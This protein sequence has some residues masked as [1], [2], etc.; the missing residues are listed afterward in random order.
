MT[1]RRGGTVQIP[2]VHNRCSATPRPESTRPPCLGPSS[3][4]GSATEWRPWDSGLVC[5]LWDFGELSLTVEPQPSCKS[6]GNVSLAHLRNC[7]LRNWIGVFG[8]GDNVSILGGCQVSGFHSFLK[9]PPST[10]LPS[11]LPPS[12]ISFSYF[13]PI[14]FNSRPLPQPPSPV[15]PT[16]I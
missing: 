11:P 5:V 4:T 8:T 14:L 9:H 6:S 15:L 3:Q 16:Q 10:C 12:T 7:C 2:Q 1:A 13:T